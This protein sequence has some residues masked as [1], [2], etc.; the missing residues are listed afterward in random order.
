MSKPEVHPEVWKSGFGYALYYH[1]GSLTLGAAVSIL[2][3]I[4]M[5]INLFL[6][7]GLVKTHQ[8]TNP[9]VKAVVYSCTCCVKCVQEIVSYVN[10]GAI[11][12]MVL[13]GDHDF[14]AAAGS[15]MR[16]VR[17]AEES[18][19]SLRGVTMVFQ[20]VGLVSTT[21][22]G[23][24][25]TFWFTGTV[26]IFSDQHSEYYLENRLGVTMCAGLIS[27]SVSM[28]FMWTLDSA[29]DTMVFCWLVEGEDD[30]THQTYAPKML[31]DV[32]R[33]DDWEPH[34][35][36]RS[37]RGGGNMPYEGMMGA[38]PMASYG[39]GSKEYGTSAGGY[40]REAAGWSSTSHLTNSP[41]HAESHSP[42]RQGR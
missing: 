15:A 6:E 39:S 25:G 22:I 27:F 37:I 4:F 14:F 9:V 13:R 10:K 18:V 41:T 1:L 8:Y 34:K 36:N 30:R 40:G 12:E 16:V 23:A 32:V 5:P 29:A 26:N 33:F 42:K 11:V 35:D 38:D 24:Y 31:R 2:L 3:Y 28:V 7:W 17:T 20:A 19:V 21:A